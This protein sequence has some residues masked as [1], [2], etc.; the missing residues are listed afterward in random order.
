MPLWKRK[1]GIL[2]H[3]NLCEDFTTI[4]SRTLKEDFEGIRA[5]MN[6]LICGHKLAIFRKLS[7]GDFC[8]QEH[9]ALFVKQQSDRGL[10]RLMDTAEPSKKRA[11]GT[12]VYAQFLLDE[13]QPIQ[14]G[15]GYLCHG[16]L[17]AVQIIPPGAA[18]PSR[19][20]VLPFQYT[21]FK[22]LFAWL[23]SPGLALLMIELLLKNTVLRRLP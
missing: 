12:R 9:R 15:R 18:L 17:A 2:S 16:P 11:I 6:C 4:Y 7:L 19:R 13:V 22:E 1:L 3:G 10:A 20:R 14:A 8:C 21:E 5:C 23:I